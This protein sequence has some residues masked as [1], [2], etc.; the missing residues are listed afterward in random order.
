MT[1]FLINSMVVTIESIRAKCTKF[2]RHMASRILKCSE[3]RGRRSSI[4]VNKVIRSHPISS[5]IAITRFF[6]FPFVTHKY[7]KRR[8]TVT[9]PSYRFFYFVVIL[10]IVN[11]KEW[12][13]RCE[14]WRIFF[15]NFQI[16]H[17]RG[18][19]YT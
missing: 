10:S 17:T 2:I 15:Q 1:R 19:S 8:D 4:N 3:K 18:F 5:T 11:N 7:S 16:F 9:I 13:E 6:I 12:Q 14:I